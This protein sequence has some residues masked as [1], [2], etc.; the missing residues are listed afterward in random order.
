[1]NL[2]VDV[3]PHTKPIC[4]SLYPSGYCFVSVVRHSR[5]TWLTVEEAPPTTLLLRSQSCPRPPSAPCLHLLNHPAWSLPHAHVF[6]HVGFGTG[7]VLILVTQ[8]WASCW[9]E[10]CAYILSTDQPKSEQRTETLQE[11]LKKPSAETLAFRLVGLKIIWKRVFRVFFF[12][13]ITKYR[14]LRDFTDSPKELTIVFIPQIELSPPWKGLLLG[15]Y[16]ILVTPTKKQ[17]RS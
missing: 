11:S 12:S 6:H 5:W 10:S 2:C 4:V 7:V 15:Y 17:S 8:H 9:V 14:L 3:L 1:M 16:R 13:R